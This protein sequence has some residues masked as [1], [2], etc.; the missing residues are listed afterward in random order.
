VYIVHI[1]PS[2][3]TG[4]NRLH[5]SA[6]ARRQ[7]A[8][9]APSRN[10]TGVLVDRGLYV[11]LELLAVAWQLALVAMFLAGQ[12]SAS[13]PPVAYGTICARLIP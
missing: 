11:G 1:H 2:V 3:A 10:G 8:E 13:H 12:F 9:A 6:K 5:I 4:K 7:R